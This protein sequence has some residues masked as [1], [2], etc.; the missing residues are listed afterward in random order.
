MRYRALGLGCRGLL[1][2]LT[3]SVPFL[4]IFAL[5]VNSQGD[6]ASG[7]VSAVETRLAA[8]AKYLASDELEGRGVGTGGLDKAAKYIADEFTKAGLRTDLFE[9]QP[10]QK[11]SVPSAV[12]RGPDDRNRLT[13]V[14]PAVVD[15]KPTTKPFKLEQDFQTL[16]LGGTGKFSAPLVFVG[17]GITA[18]DKNYDDYA[19]LDVKGKV[20]VVIRKEPQ[21]DK[22]DSVF[23]GKQASPYAPFVRKIANATDHGAAAVILINDLFSIRQARESEERAWGELVDKLASTRA[24]FQKKEQPTAEDWAAHRKEIGRLAEQIQLSSQKLSGDF[25]SI[26]GFLEAGQGSHS[27]VLPVMFCKRA[28]MAEVLRAGGIDLDQVEREIDADLKPRSKELAGCQVDGET[29]VIHRRA[30]VQNVVGVLEGEGPLADET[31]VIGAHYDHVGKG[32]PGSGSLA[33]PWSTEVHNGADDNASGTA[34]LL[35]VAR[36]FAKQEKKPRRRLV[37]IAFTGEE[38]GLLGSAHYVK[39]PRFPLEK[40]VA[41]LNMDMVGRLADNKLIVYGT[42]TATEFNPLVDRLNEQHKFVITKHPEG[43]GPSD[44]ASFYGKQIPVFHFFTGTHPEYHRPSDDAH[45]L[46]IEG[47]RRIVSMVSDTATAIVEAEKRPEYLEVKGSAQIG[48]SGDRPYFGSIPDFAEGVEG[49]ALMGV[50][51]GSPADR[52]GLKGGDVIVKV[53]DS[54]VRSLDDFDLALRK[55]KVG[56]KVLVTVKRGKEMVTVTV[57]LDPPRN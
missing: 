41:M 24:E 31:V 56:D 39:N 29:D 9:G 48:R 51:K 57:T 3:V 32:G 8:D 36:Y 21:Q 22:D 7:S 43:F 19:G 12:D 14:G 6:E 35:E 5:T 1:T 42:G 52:A 2:S 25:D 16:A 55:F 45:L 28:A 27:K 15:G 26:P 13:L 38:R 30:D 23:N 49:Y 11:F 44:H 40:T 33:P 37:F 4:A 20:V 34:A 17:Y 10:F 53:G 50:A 54:N 18:A 46:N 47:M